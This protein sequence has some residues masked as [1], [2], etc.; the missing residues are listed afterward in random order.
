MLKVEI[1]KGYDKPEKRT[2]KGQ[3]GKPDVDRFSQKAYLHKGSA[4]PVEFT[5]PL[6]SLAQ[7]YAVGLY[8]LDPNCIDVNKYG[9]L[10][11]N[12]Y[13]MVLVPVSNETL[14]VASNG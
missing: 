3:D 7:T 5:L 14:K 12:S 6:E 9:R 1:V 8:T 4:F 11:V 10:E 13:K 2:F